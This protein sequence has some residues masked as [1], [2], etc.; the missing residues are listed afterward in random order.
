MV[1]NKEYS[2][3]LS[4]IASGGGLFIFHLLERKPPLISEDG[5]SP[6]N[7]GNCILQQVI[8]YLRKLS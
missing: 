2:A 6:S 3:L 7:V 4:G 5:Q 8:A 1:N